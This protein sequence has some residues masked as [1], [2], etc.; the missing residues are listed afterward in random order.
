MGAMRVLCGEGRGGAVQGSADRGELPC[1]RP[2]WGG[3]DVGA[4]CPAVREPGFGS[5]IG[6]FAG[7][8]VSGAV[9]SCRVASLGMLRGW[10]RALWKTVAADGCAWPSVFVTQGFL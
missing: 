8:A 6:R 7:L 5:R 10:V 1:G 2:S 9:R 3:L 4:A